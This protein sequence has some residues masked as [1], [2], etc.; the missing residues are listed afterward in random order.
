M[1]TEDDRRTLARVMHIRDEY[2]ALPLAKALT[3]PPAMVV[4][5]FIVIRQLRGWHDERRLASN[6]CVDGA[7]AS[8]HPNVV[9]NI[10]RC[11]VG[12]KYET[13]DGERFITIV[14][15]A[16]NMAIHSSLVLNGKMRRPQWLVYA[17]AKLHP[18]EAEDFLLLVE[19]RYDAVFNSE[20]AL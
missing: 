17:N 3:V 19:L 12:G 10:G 9:R 14:R 7:Y 15:A 1:R 20:G 5:D 4:G 18:V 6:V 2:V 8:L 13:D 11:R 16:Q